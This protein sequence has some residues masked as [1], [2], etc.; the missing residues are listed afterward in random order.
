MWLLELEKSSSLNL[1]HYKTEIGCGEEKREKEEQ[2][3]G[4]QE[5]QEDRERRKSDQCGP[6]APRPGMLREGLAALGLSKHI[7][8]KWKNGREGGCEQ[9]LLSATLLRTPLSPHLFMLLLGATTGI[10]SK[11][12]REMVTSISVGPWASHHGPWGD[13]SW[14][15]RRPTRAMLNFK[16]CS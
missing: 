4:V 6:W 14:V 9:R 16:C 12:L 11:D 3:G 5:A 7:L 1:Q 13:I 10:Q 8:H 15:E 2:E